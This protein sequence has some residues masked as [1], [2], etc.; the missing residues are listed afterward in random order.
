EMKVLSDS[1]SLAFGPVPSRRLG[2]SLGINNIPPKACTY[3]CIYCQI[4]KTKHNTINRKIFYEPSEILLQV[5]KRIDKAKMQHEQIDYLTFVS[6]GEPTLDINI[7]V[8]ISLL[9]QFGIPVAVITNASMLW[10]NEVRKELL[11]ADFVSLKVDA[12]SESI[13]KFIDRPHRD[14]KLSMIM[15]GIKDFAELFKGKLVTETMLLHGIDYSNEF[16]KTATFLADLKKLSNAYIAIPTRPPVEKWV[17][18]AEEAKLIDA[19]QIFSEKLGS[20]R[21]EYLIGYEGNK[22]AF[23]GNVKEDLLS[24]MAVHPMCTEAV[25][26]FLKKAKT[27]WKIIEYL[28]GSGEI[29]ELKYEGKKFYMRKLTLD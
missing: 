3:S 8:E 6:D 7:G 5:K 20:D 13:W 25:K 15:A 18:C 16:E 4:G 26:E 2:K 23:T 1:P 19:F 27:D 28:L 21:V 11:N 29:S 22:F 12:T 24:I 9:K 14:L 17:K 10:S